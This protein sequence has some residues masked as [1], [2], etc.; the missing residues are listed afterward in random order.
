MVAAHNL[1]PQKGLAAKKLPLSNF[2]L[3]AAPMAM[4]VP[5]AISHSHTA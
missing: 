4:V 3:I 2:R 5:I 1:L